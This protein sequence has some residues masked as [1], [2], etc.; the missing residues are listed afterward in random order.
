MAV[1]FL[2]PQFPRPPSPG[3]P[4]P[5]IQWYRRE[6]DL[7]PE[8][9]IQGGVLE[10]PRMRPEYAGEYVCLVRNPVGESESVVSIRVEGKSLD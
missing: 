3:S 8:H 9:I 5:V 4:P 1:L 6:G 2:S 10:I 7:P